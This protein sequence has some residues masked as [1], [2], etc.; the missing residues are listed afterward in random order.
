MIPEW[1]G[2]DFDA[3]MFLKEH[4]IVD[5]GGGILQPPT[6]PYEETPRVSAAINY[7][8]DEWDYGYGG[9]RS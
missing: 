8:C 3:L 5:S 9:P 1:D 4:D 6:W 2:D 7:L